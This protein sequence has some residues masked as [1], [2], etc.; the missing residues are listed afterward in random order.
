MLFVMLFSGLSLLSFAQASGGQI[1]RK[2]SKTARSQNN[3][4]RG[5]TVSKI[6]KKYEY[7][8][9]IYNSQDVFQAIPAYVSAKEEMDALQ[10]KYESNLKQMQDEFAFQID[11][12][13]KTMN[14]LSEKERAVREDQLQT[15]YL[16]IL[17]TYKA[18]SASLENEGRNKSNALY[19]T[20]DNTAKNI[21]NQESIYE[22]FSFNRVYY[23]NPVYCLDI[24]NYIINRLGGHR[25][26]NPI[27]FNTSAIKPKIGY[28]YTDQ[29]P[30]FNP[31]ENN[32]FQQSNWERLKRLAKMIAESDGYICIVDVNQL[33]SIQTEYAVNVTH[34][35]IERYKL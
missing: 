16:K 24:T 14:K 10:A 32:E 31:S 21:R 4:N 26:A 28:V 1:R 8:F 19:A 20:I 23:A 35:L 30:G 34:Q 9:A 33:S 22:I 29:I 5:Q 27:S 7:R 13:E 11:N 3:N 25:V 17:Q 12:F 15:M 6:S 18:D 2:E